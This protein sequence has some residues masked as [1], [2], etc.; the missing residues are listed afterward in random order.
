MRDVKFDE[1]KKL[2]EFAKDCD[3]R[4]EFVRKYNAYLVAKER[5][6]NNDLSLFRKAF[7]NRYGKQKFRELF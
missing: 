6:G 3:S 1:L 4:G 7:L 2:V 5:V